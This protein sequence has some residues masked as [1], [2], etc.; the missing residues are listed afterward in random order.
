M[1]AIIIMIIIIVCIRNRYKGAQMK[2][3]CE[4]KE[5]YTYIMQMILA[6]NRSVII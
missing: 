4:Y 2:A 3:Q 5:Y 6:I 1:V